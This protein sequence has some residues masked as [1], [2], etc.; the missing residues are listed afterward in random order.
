MKLKT[1]LLLLV[2]LPVPRVLYGSFR[3]RF[4]Q[5]RF[6]L[7]RQA[8]SFQFF[9][10]FLGRVSRFEKNYRKLVSNR[11]LVRTL[12]D[13]KCINIQ[14]PT[15]L[16]KGRYI[17]ASVWKSL[18]DSFILKNAVASGNNKIINKTL[19]SRFSVNLWLLFSMLIPYSFLTK[20]WYYSSRTFYIAEEILKLSSSRSLVDY[21]F[22]CS[23]SV[24]FLLQVDLDRHHIHKRNLYIIKSPSEYVL[25]KDSLHSF[26]PDPHFELP[27][28]I[29]LAYNA[30]SH[31]SQFLSLSRIDFYIDDDK[32][33]FGEITNVPGSSFERFSS[34]SLDNSLGTIALKL[35]Q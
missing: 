2:L 30:S 15:I 17:S 14:L 11:H 26:K 20:E 21:K 8:L 29:D 9:Q 6:S 31:L 7:S 18:P 33:I 34:S 5:R 4:Q 16:W 1:Y 28:S 19:H 13:F 10:I 35:R 32:V 24:P 12:F 23:N 25:L 22:F 3:F 27:A